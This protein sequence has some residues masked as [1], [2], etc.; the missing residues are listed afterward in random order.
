MLSIYKFD[1][2]MGQLK[3]QAKIESDVWID[4]VD[5]TP[6]EMTK[7]QKKA[8]VPEA[9]LLYGLDPDEGARYEYDEDYDAHLLI[10]D[11]PVVSQDSKHRVAY[12]TVPLAVILTTTAIITI[13][14]TAQPLLALFASG[15]VAGF[16]PKMK[17]RAALQMLYQIS[18]SYLAYL[19]D[20]NKA[21]EALET[22]LQN[23]LKNE[24]LYALMGIQRGLVYFMMSLRTDRN[25]LDQLKRTN[26]LHLNEEDLDLLDDTI[27]EN[28][29]G[30]EM[31]QISDSII[32][33]TADTY[34]SVIS[35]NMNSVMK[36]LTSYS[37]ILTIPTLVFSFYGM[38]VEL[39]FAGMHVS[40]LITIIISLVISV[41]IAFQFYKNKYF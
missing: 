1:D 30:T 28:Q 38:N 12:K 18:V 15:K 37:I 23:N 41:L 9:F 6:E 4:A 31:A 34:S 5:P 10:F 40:W 11:M 26:P 2:T 35:N 16:N 3:T 25:V 8:R 36:F 22:K 19:R 21:R 33:E 29:Q 13:D 20:I 17:S 14:N 7:L 32:N 24:E 27:I 39:P